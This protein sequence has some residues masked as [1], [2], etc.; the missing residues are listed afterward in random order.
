MQR[1]MKYGLFFVGLALLTVFVVEVTGQRPVHA[2]QYVM[3]GFAKCVFFL[4][5]LSLGEQVGFLA[6]Y[7][8]SSVATVVLVCAYGR[9]ALALGRRT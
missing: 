7:V 4:L 5:L 3:I 9:S 6:A 1:A 8:A 2:A